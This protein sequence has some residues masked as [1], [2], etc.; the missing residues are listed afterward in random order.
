MRQDFR[1]L[2]RVVTNLAVLDFNGPAN[3]MRV[4]SLH[5]GVELDEVRENTGFELAI[6]DD[7]AETLT[8]THE[9]LKLIDERLDP[10]NQ[11]AGVF[12]ES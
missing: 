1:D 9:Q 11:R 7:W 5:P 4:V 8:P 10:E 2:R 6:A 12:S 3:S